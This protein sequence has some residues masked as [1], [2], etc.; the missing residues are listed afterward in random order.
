[1]D[2]EGRGMSIVDLEL[3]NGDRI[4]IA[5]NTVYSILKKTEDT[6]TVYTMQW[7]DGIEVSGHVDDVMGEWWAAIG[8]WMVDEDEESE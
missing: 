6:T 8:M 5:V 2:A 4:G 3:T 7:P 1:M